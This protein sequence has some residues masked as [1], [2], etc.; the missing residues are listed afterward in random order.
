[1]TVAYVIG[2]MT[3]YK[4]F[5]FPAFH[6]AAEV[7]REQFGYKVL[8]PA[9]NF[10]GRTDLDWQT[11][12]DEGLRQIREEAEVVFM[13]PGWEDSAGAQR[14]VALAKEL[15]RL[16]APLKADVGHWQEV[17]LRGEKDPSFVTPGHPDAEV[18]AHVIDGEG[19]VWLERADGDFEFAEVDWLRKS[20]EEIEQSYGFAD[21]APVIILNLAERVT[22]PIRGSL[23]IAPA[24]TEHVV[25][26]AQN[27]YERIDVLDYL[28]DPPGESEEPI[29]LPEELEP[30]PH[31]RVKEL[32][33]QVRGLREVIDRLEREL[34]EGETILD[35][36]K[37]LVHGARRAT[38]DH[39]L[40]NHERIAKIWSGI[41]GVDI[42]AEQAAMC[43]VG[44]K[45][46]REAFKPK[47]DNVVDLAGYALV[48]W[49]IREERARRE[50]RQPP[51]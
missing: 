1:M 37:G 33:E 10:E 3:G 45:L 27:G 36:A 12:L 7:L 11:Y 51:G 5:N 50:G 9:E 14:E 40:D 25:D 2:P 8:N 32:T 24:D 35:E 4:D 30:R 48:L 31:R 15:G 47:R 44:V 22:R 19:D 23:F 18:P 49:E 41:L 13:L 17:P 20:L 42:T 39:P 26:V 6:A 29:D 43:M 38:Y 21:D 16:C 28:A 46:S 34:E